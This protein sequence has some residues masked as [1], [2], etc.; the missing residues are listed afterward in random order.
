MGIQLATD[1]NFELDELTQ[2]LYGHVEAL[3]QNQHISPPGVPDGKYI[4]KFPFEKYSPVFEIGVE[5]VEAEGVDK[6]LFPKPDLELRLSCYSTTGINN[7]IGPDPNKFEAVR[8]LTRDLAHA[9]S[10]LGGVKA[11]YAVDG[12]NTQVY[13]PNG[14]YR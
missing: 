4:W 14:V 9:L 2:A 1:D 13:I 11:A 6:T 10:S 12:E 3:E 7:P 8:D 5:L